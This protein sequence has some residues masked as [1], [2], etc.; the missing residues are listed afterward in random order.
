MNIILI[1]FMGSGKTVVGKALAERLGRAF[2]DMDSIIEEEQGM[3]V[4]EIFRT[5]GEKFFRLWEAELARRMGE[6]RDAVIACGGGVVLNRENLENLSRN[7]IVVCLDA[8][9]DTLVNRLKDMD[10]RPL[11][12]GGETR[13]RVE[14]LL[15]ERQ[16]FYDRIEFKVDTSGRSVDEVVDEIA[17]KLRA[18][19]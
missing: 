17:D 4:A 5:K 2:F 10:D 8:D 19:C 16:P 12:E 3:T 6:E 13:K 11:L 15:A 14:S 7:G 9:L 18:R 1:G